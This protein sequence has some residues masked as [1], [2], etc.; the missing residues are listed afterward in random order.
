MKNNASH[1][2]KKFHSD[3]TFLSKEKSKSFDFLSLKKP[4]GVY[5]SEKFPIVDRLAMYHFEGFLSLAHTH[6]EK[7]LQNTYLKY[8]SNWKLKLELSWKGF[9]ANK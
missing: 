2:K 8:I 6:Q 5:F 7:A 1:K 3:A 9:D 4:Q